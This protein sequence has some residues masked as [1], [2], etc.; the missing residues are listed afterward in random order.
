L[1]RGPGS[2][3]NF[4]A[5]GVHQDFGLTTDLYH[6]NLLG[7]A[8]KWY[9]DNVIKQFNKDVVKGMRGVVLW[10]P[11]LM[12]KPLTHMPLCVLDPSTVSVHDCVNS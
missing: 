6:N 7:Y 4:Y 9:A 8:G 2:K 12:D 1:R 11:I 10:R 3:N 5:Q